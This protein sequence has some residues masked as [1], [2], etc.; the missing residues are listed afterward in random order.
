MT[1][2]DVDWTRII[3]GLVA[4]AVGYLFAMLDRRVTQSIRD[5]RKPE[6]E[7]VEKIVREESALSIF[8]D[9]NQQAEV[10]LDGEVVEAQSITPDQRK[11]HLLFLLPLRP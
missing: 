3:I 1:S 6:V 9:D 7:V 5:K 11:Y 2:I 10:R 8:L 4:F